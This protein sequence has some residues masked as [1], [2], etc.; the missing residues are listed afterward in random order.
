ML[1]WRMRERTDSGSV[2][3]GDE[4][5]GSEK[6]LEHGDVG[7]VVTG[8]LLPSIGIH[9]RSYIRSLFSCVHEKPCVISDSTV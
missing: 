5:D 6:L 9:T 4:E 2:D 7:G 3:K 8:F 1:P